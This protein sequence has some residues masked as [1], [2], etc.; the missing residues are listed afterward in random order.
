V[1]YQLVRRVLMACW[2]QRH[3]FFGVCHHSLASCNSAE[4]NQSGYVLC[5]NTAG[6]SYTVFEWLF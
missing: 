6:H 4:V 2:S 5:H 3:W 1:Q